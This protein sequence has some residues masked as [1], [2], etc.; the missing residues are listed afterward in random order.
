MK[1]KIRVL[2]LCAMLLTFCSSAEAQQPTKVPRIGL[3]RSGSVASHASSHEAFR[4][5]LRELGYEEAKN[6]LIEYRYAEGK[7]ERWPALANEL[8]RLKVDIIVVG[9][10]GVAR[11]TQQ[12]TKTI[13]IVVGTAGDLIRTGLVASLARP[14]GN[15]TGATELSPDL[16]GKRLELLKE[17]VPKASRVAVLVGAGSGPGSTD[18]DDMQEMETPARYEIL[19]TFRLPM[20]Q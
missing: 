4:Q 14:G 19:L 7:S 2:T 15:I 20:P 3:L 12:A 1:K 16:A 13:P 17:A 8:V 11:A 5:G 6:I 10:S 9:G 18:Q